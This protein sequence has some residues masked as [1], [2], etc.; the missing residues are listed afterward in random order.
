MKKSF[1][2][3]C[4]ILTN[5]S[6]CFSQVI[7]KQV[8][9][10]L[11]N[12]TGI[13]YTNQQGEIFIQGFE[14][15]NAGSYLFLNGSASLT[16]L[17]KF[18]ATKNVYRKTYKDDLG[19]Q[20]FIYGSKIHIFNYLSN[21]LSV[22][23]ANGNIL[24]K[25]NHITS[26][27]INSYRFLDSNLIIDVNKPKSFDLDY[28]LYNLKGQKIKN[29]N[30]IY[31]LPP[32]VYRNDQAVTGVIYL[33]KWDNK[34]L[35]WYIDDKRLDFERFWITNDNGDVLKTKYFQSKQFGNGFEEVGEFKK[36]RNGTIYILGYNGKDGIITELSPAEMFK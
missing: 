14:I 21:D 31:N 18:N 6:I 28:K 9:I 17:V 30:N 8:H 15:D 23:D 16:S 3:A 1:W 4:I 10:P 20:L 34:Y 19:S 12:L 35:F 36:L 32:K 25:Y 7:K 11:N 24:S 29:I 27:K 33:G 26:D 2:V 5:S 13:P 22:L